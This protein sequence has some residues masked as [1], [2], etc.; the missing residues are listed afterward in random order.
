M[1]LQE[2]IL[3]ALGERAVPCQAIYRT[4]KGDQPC[5]IDLALS[6]LLKRGAITRELGHY[7]RG[8]VRVKLAPEPQKPA[9]PT[10]QKPADVVPIDPKGQ[11]LT[12]RERE[13]YSL[14]VAGFRCREIMKQLGLSAPA[15]SNHLSNARR[16][17]GIPKSSGASNPAPSAAA[18]LSAAPSSE[19]A[20]PAT[21]GAAPSSNPKPKEEVPAPRKVIFSPAM[22]TWLIEEQRYTAELLQLAHGKVDQL[23]E[24]LAN[25]EELVRMATQKEGAT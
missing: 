6:A 18:P 13:V 15:V 5:E 22:T 10:V 25:L 17:L 8:K 12:A 4:L 16:K 23:Q 19:G 21:V 2:R 9:P 20:E 3:E 7:Q 14:A 1:T 24:R 11:E